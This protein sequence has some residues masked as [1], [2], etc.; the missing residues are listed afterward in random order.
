[1]RKTEYTVDL[2]MWSDKNKQLD[3][4]EDPQGFKLWRNKAKAF[5]TF[6]HASVSKLLDWAASQ[7]EMITE[8][9]EYE[10]SHLIP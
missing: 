10:A 6:R 8:G 2:K 3:L 1:M 9:R 4:G 5:L 7:A